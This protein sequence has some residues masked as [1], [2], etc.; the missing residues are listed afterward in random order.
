M[1]SSN[2]SV[3]IPLYNKVGSVA[4]SLRSVL[5]QTLPPLEIIVVDDGSTD[6]SADV[7]NAIMRENPD[8]PI[9]LVCQ[10]NAGVSAARNRAIAEASGEYVALLDADDRWEENHIE[11][12]AAMIERFPD[13][14]IYAS[15][16]RVD[17][18]YNI[19]DGDTPA[20]EGVVD[21]FALSLKQYVA[22]PSATVLRR[23]A[24]VAAGGFPEGMRMGEDQYLWTKMARRG[25]VCFSP[26]RTVIYSRAADNRSATIYRPEQTRFSLE[27]LYDSSSSDDSNEYVVRAALYKALVQSVQGDTASAARAA[28]FFSYT[29]RN[30]R[31]LRKL[32]TLNAL[33]VSWRRPLLNAYNYLAWKIARK[34]L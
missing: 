28:R 12:A 31:A 32:R 17:D 27:E 19:T 33:P 5:A 22:I 29:H 7:V 34:G 21:F 24:T 13:C 18:G 14:D 20:V 11:R 15:S 30:R 25:A 26:V 8:A 6:G 1:K 2:I 3:I 23:S 16:F 9:R 4:C 10:T